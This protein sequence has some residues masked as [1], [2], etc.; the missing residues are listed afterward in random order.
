MNK[1][2]TNDDQD[3]PM[4]SKID[5]DIEEDNTCE[6]QDKV[7]SCLF[8]L[9]LLADIAKKNIELIEENIKEFRTYIHGENLDE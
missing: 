8:K 5:S 3:G 7:L 1:K 4:V 9:Q 6:F 2:I